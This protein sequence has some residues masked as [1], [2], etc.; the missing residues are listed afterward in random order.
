MEL[1]IHHKLFKCLLIKIQDSIQFD[2]KLFNLVAKASGKNPRLPSKLAVPPDN[3]RKREQRGTKMSTFSLFNIINSS[4][5]RISFI[6]TGF[7][8]IP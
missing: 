5:L 8:G 1:G 4:N 3:V 7:G 6:I 2:K